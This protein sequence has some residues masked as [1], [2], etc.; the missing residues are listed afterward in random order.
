MDVHVTLV[1]L[2]NIC[3]STAGP[4]GAR[5][6]LNRNETSYASMASWRGRD[7]DGV[8]GARGWL[9]ARDSGLR[10]TRRAARTAIVMPALFAVGSQVI[11]NPD[12]ATFAA[13][14]SFAMLL[15]ADFGGMLGERLAA[16]SF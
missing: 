1:A 13:F 3:R 5:R 14:G 2:D 15:L 9:L 8:S 6:P 7:G 12:V 16:Q 10:A 11:G 4:G